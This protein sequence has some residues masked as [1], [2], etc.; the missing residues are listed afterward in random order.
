MNIVYLTMKLYAT[1]SPVIY[2]K[3]LRDL[4]LKHGF[5]FNRSS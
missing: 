2:L 1:V 3:G 4:F 5:L